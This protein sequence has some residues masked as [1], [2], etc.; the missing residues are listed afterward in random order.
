MV[1]LPSNYTKLNINIEGIELIDKLPNNWY[2]NDE[3]WKN[4]F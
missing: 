2:N 4:G 1:K 3:L